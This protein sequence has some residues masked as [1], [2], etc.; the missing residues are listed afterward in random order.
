MDILTSTPVCVYSGGG[1]APILESVNQRIAGRAYEYF[2]DR[3]SVDGHSL[4]DWF[5]AERDVIV[6]LATTLTIDD[7]D[8]TVDVLLPP[9]DMPDVAVHIA[10]CQIL[11]SSGIDEH[12]LQ[13]CQLI[14]LPYE[15]SMDGVDA[16]QS[17]NM[18]RVTAAL[19]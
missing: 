17:G 15:V 7:E 13:I 16:E 14:D 2:L 4:E 18:I 5:D 11:I 12:G 19:A 10:P 9:H 1:I 6:K 8:I 3:G